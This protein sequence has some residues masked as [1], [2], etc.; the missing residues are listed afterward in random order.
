MAC[1]VLTD[2][3]VSTENLTNSLVISTCKD[4]FADVTKNW[5][6]LEQ[7]FLHRYFNRSNRENT[8]PK[9]YL[10]GGFPLFKNSPDAYTR[11]KCLVPVH[12]TCNRPIA[13][14]GEEKFTI[15]HTY[16]ERNAIF[17]TLPTVNTSATVLLAAVTADYLKSRTICQ[18]DDEVIYNRLLMYY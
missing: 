2:F 11:S 16:V 14:I 17:V 9:I 8:L 13:S 18:R 7:T 1:R 3:L 10:Q 4:R 5:L 6:E 15:L 12:E